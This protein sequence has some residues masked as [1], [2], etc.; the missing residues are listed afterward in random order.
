MAEGR[1]S[2][3][4]AG[5]TRRQVAGMGDSGRRVDSVTSLMWLPDFSVKDTGIPG[6]IDGPGIP[7]FAAPCSLLTADPACVGTSHAPCKPIS[8]STSRTAHHAVATHPQLMDNMDYKTNPHV[9]PPYSYASLIC[10]AMEA[11]DKPHITLSAIYKWITNNFCYFRHADPTWQ[12]GDVETPCLFSLPA[13]LGRPFHS[14]QRL[15]PQYTNQLKNG[16][17]KKRRM[18]PVQL[19]PAFTERAQPEAQ[20]VASPAASAPASKNILNVS[21]E[22]QQ[23]L[24]E[25]EEVTGDLNSNPAGHKRKQPSLQQVAKAPQLSSSALLSQGE[26][27]ELGLL[28]GDLDW[29]AIF[30]TSRNGEFSRFEDLELTPLK[31]PTKVNLDL[32][33]DGQHMDCAQGQEQVLTESNQNNLEFETLIA[34]SSYSMPGMKMTS[35]TMSTSS[36]FL[37]P[38]MPL[39]QRMGATGADTRFLVVWDS[40]G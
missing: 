32:A 9:K 19:H 20:C 1:P 7:S 17:S 5:E 13:G 33:A 10:M 18:T 15:D 16:A 12:A 29:E 4:W 2:C 25:F 38:A 36:S 39:C 26:Q 8:S 37:S 28:E 22:S 35:P 21:V 3:Q 6:P 11:S 34:T 14:F 23:L 31:K 30:D 40:I 27:P 24:E